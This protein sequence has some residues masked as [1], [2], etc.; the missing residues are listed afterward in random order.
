MSGNARNIDKQTLL[1]LAFRL[2]SVTDP[3]TTD[4]DIPTLPIDHP[5]YCSPQGPMYE[6][7]RW[8]LLTRP[9][10]PCIVNFLYPTPVP[11]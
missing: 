5:A 9:C 6:F 10:Q 4:D 7:D 1:N 8:R 2:I 11:L 3:L